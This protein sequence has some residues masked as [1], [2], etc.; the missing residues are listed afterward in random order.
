MAKAELGEWQEV[1]VQGKKTKEAKKRFIPAFRMYDL[2]H[3]CAT[4]LLK[5][6]I[7][8]KIVSERLGH[9]SITLTLDTYSHVLPDMQ[10]AAADELERAFGG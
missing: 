5:R 10:S 1:E 7:N 4:T 3:T 9:A 8:P 2:R 6:G